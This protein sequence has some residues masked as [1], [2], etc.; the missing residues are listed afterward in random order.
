LI[1]FYRLFWVLS[2]SKRAANV[3]KFFNLE[4]GRPKKTA[5]KSGLCSILH[6]IALFSIL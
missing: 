3:I 1:G 5:K 2:L 4:K 6:A